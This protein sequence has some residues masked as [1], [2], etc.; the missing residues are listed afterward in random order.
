[1]ISYTGRTDNGITYAGGSGG[2][3]F[4]A[5]LYFSPDAANGGEEGMDG[6]ELGISFGLGGGLTLGL[7]TQSIEDVDN[8]VFGA[9]LTGI[10]AG[11]FSL[12]FGLQTNDDDT[13]FLIDAAIGSVYLHF[14]TQ[15]LD[16][17]D[18][19][20]SMFTVGY[21]QGLGPKTTAWYEYQAVDNDDVASAWSRLHCCSCN[22]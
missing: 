10:S 18:A 1:M 7:A 13:S 20:R 3:N 4:G 5:T 2:V 8:D 19:D 16:A 14:E 12:G 15:S 22:A 11:S 17:A 21:T 9:A 6:T